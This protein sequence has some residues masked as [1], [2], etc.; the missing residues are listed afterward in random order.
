MPERNNLRKERLI[1]L[2]VSVHNGQ[3][4]QQ[5]R[6]VPIMDARK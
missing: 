3:E 2:T 6:E 4:A 1:F 5:S